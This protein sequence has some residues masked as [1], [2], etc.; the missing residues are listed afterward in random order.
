MTFVALESAGWP[1][2]VSSVAVDRM[3]IA[4]S[5]LR[6]RAREG[7][8]ATT[9]LPAWPEKLLFITSGPSTRV[10]RGEEDT[11]QVRA[12]RDALRVKRDL[13]QYQKKT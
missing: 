8:A 9:R 6:C 11:W 3:R 5:C 1:I 4:L 7:A 12:S 2:V 10:A 13:V